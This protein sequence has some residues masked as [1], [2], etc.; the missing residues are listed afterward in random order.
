MSC[1]VDAGN[2]PAAGE[3]TA[4][5]AQHEIRTPGR[6]SGRSQITFMFAIG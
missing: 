1:S 2:V 6:I 4:I 3:D 5:I